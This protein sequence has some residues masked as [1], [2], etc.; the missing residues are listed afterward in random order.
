MYLE[1]IFSAPDIQKQLPDD[2]ALFASI[3]KSW[4][5]LMKKTNENPI[6]AQKWNIMHNIRDML[7]VR[8]FA[9]ELICS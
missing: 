7:Q 2:A 4:R 9:F 5:D 8:C 1:S 3:D 6:V